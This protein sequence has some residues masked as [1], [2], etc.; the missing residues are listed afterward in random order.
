MILFSILIPLLLGADFTFES[1]F[2]ENYEW[3]MIGALPLCFVI[4]AKGKDL[5]GCSIYSI[6]RIFSFFAGSVRF[7]KKG[8]P[9]QS[10]ML[11]L[12]VL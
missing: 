4:T 12:P 8:I 7:Y 10:L 9:A 11:S 1:L 3:M 2:W 6:L 5:N